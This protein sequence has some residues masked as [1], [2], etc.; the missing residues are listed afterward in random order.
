MWYFFRAA[1]V[2]ISG[3]TGREAVMD[4]RVF[5]ARLKELR[6]AAGLSQKELAEKIGVSR[7][8]V[9]HW[10]QGL[11]EPGLFVGPALAEALSV[12]LES[13]FVEPAV[14]HKPRRGRPTK[15]ETEAPPE[16]PKKKRKG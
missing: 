9:S 14:I 5:A 1:Y 4:Q 2:A 7:R 11:R 15:Q 16:P 8:A 6:Q 10:E 13:L 12:N 3:P